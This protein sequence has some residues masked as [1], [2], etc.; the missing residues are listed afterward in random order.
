MTV[1]A[2]G[3]LVV[4]VELVVV[5]GGAVVEV[6]VVDTSDATGRVVVVGAA[7]LEPIV[8]GI[9][10]VVSADWSPHAANSMQ[11]AMTAGIVRSFRIG[12]G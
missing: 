2:E 6:E 11:N 10:V 1:A 12:R 4:D 9:V 3:A 7:W 8:V 5:V